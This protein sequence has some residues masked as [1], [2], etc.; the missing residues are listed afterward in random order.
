MKKYR[1]T[2]KYGDPGK[3]LN[4]STQITVE[5]ENQSTAMNLAVNKFKASNPTCRN[6]DAIATNAKEI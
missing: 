5:A 1:V 6:K 2:V 3:S 4:L